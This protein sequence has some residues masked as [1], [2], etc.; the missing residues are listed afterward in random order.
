MFVCVVLECSVGCPR[1]PNA[2]HPTPLRLRDTYR[3]VR[4][5]CP[6]DVGAYGG[7]G[8]AL[9]NGNGGG[10]KKSRENHL[11]VYAVV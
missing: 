5:I 2:L 1:V 10:L 6:Y 7:L 8:D 4:V 9:I 11:E 3:G